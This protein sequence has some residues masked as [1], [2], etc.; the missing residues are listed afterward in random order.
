MSIEQFQALPVAESCR[1]VTFKEVEVLPPEPPGAATLV[2]RGTVPCFNMQVTLV[3][4]VYVRCPE[5]WAIEVIG[6][7]PDGI[8]VTAIKEY[9]VSRSLAGIIGSRG[10]EVIGANV[11]ERVELSGGCT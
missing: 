9:E 10:I 7:L 8:C 5:Y 6:C 1:L 4:R 3:P 2:V 11:T